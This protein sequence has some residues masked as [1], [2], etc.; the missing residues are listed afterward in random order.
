MPVSGLEDGTEQCSNWHQNLVPEWRNGTRFA[1]QSTT[2]I[3]AIFT[4]TALGVK[5]RLIR[6]A[7]N[8]F[9]QLQVLQNRPRY[10]KSSK[11]VCQMKWPLSTVG[12]RAFPVAA[13]RLWNSR[14]SH[15]T[16]WCSS[17]SIFCCRLK[18][19]LFSL[20]YLAFWL[21]SHLYSARA[22]TRHFGPYNRHYI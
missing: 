9:F 4:H 6:K 1:C 20:S 5:R 15:I 12:N 10:L 22:V 19:H 13:A 21:F 14:P 18:S 11:I 16:H 8:M 17:V 7:T 2:E 3:S